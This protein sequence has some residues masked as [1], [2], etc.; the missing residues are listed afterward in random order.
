LYHVYAGGQLVCSFE[1]NSTL[2]GGSDTNRVAYYYHE[3]NLN[4][5]TALSSGGTSGT[6]IEVDA[7]YPFGRVMTA[8][9]QANFKVS[10]QFTG[11]IKDDDT[12]LCFYNTRYYDP[13]LDR[14]IQADTTIPDLGN[15]QSYN[16]Y[17]Y[18]LNNPLKYTDPSGHDE[19]Y[20]GASGRALLQ[21]EDADATRV[22]QGARQSAGTM[23]AVMKT[24][25]AVTPAGT[26]MNISE[27]VTGKEA[28]TGDKLTVGQRIGSGAMAAIPGVLKGAG[29]LAKAGKAA[30]AS[31]GVWALGDLERGVAIEDRLAA[32]EYKEWFRVGSL[33][34]GKFP[35]VDFQKGNN[36][37]SLKTVDTTGS[38]WLGDMQK[39]I[40]ELGGL[41]HAVD[42]KPANMLLDIRV[43]PGGAQAAHQLVKF[44]EQHKVTVTVSEIQ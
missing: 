39:H 22:S 35:L 31:R 3:D 44:G 26:A 7:Y 21:E 28:Y 12:G 20:N 17:S 29:K 23:A 4:S 6:Q 37:V 38:S 24:A 27:A 25:V 36:L 15:P 8:S 33:N 5:S 16:R 30:A 11:Q 9:P 19:M 14:F 13:L 34:N 18:C 43:Q 1:T 41:G 10:R 32:T 42:G 2:F 40:E